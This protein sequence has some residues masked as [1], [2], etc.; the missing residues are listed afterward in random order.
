MWVRMRRRCQ[1][2]PGRLAL[3]PLCRSCCSSICPL[4]LYCFCPGPGVLE[5]NIRPSG[6]GQGMPQ[7]GFHPARCM[8]G[9]RMPV[10]ARFLASSTEQYLSL[11]ELS[12]RRWRKGLY[13]FSVTANRLHRQHCIQNF[14]LYFHCP[15]YTFACPS[16]LNLPNKTLC[17]PLISVWIIFHFT[18]FIIYYSDS[19]R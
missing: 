3:L 14:N 4:L 16:S 2:G 8:S 11:H 19:N 7:A 17:A 6:R 15:C 18:I 9:C 5:G 13:L 1:L 12:G 10:C